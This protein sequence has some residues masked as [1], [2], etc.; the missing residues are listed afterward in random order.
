MLHS[1]RKVNSLMVKMTTI[2][3]INRSFRLTPRVNRHVKAT[4]NYFGCSVGTLVSLLLDATHIS[5]LEGGISDEIIDKFYKEVNSH[6]DTETYLF[7][8]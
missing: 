6:A 4:A 3:T 5:Q 2:K 7:K 1:T 8:D